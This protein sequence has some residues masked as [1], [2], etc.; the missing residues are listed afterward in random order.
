MP[1]RR[2]SRIIQEPTKPD[3]PGLWPTTATRCST[4][5]ILCVFEKLL[6]QVRQQPPPSKPIHLQTNTD[7]D[8]VAKLVRFLFQLLLES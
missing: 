1:V 6:Q 7:I 2:T 8:Y 3:I 4:D 5:W